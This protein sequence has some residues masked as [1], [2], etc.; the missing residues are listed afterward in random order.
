MSARRIGD[1]FVESLIIPHARILGKTRLG[2]SGS[3]WQ[4]GRL[5]VILLP[6]GTERFLSGEGIEIFGGNSKSEK[7]W[8]GSRLCWRLGFRSERERERE[9]GKK[10]PETFHGKR[11]LPTEHGF[12]QW[13]GSGT[14]K[15][16]L[17]PPV[18]TRAGPAGPQQ[19]PLV[20]TWGG[21]IEFRGSV[22][23]LPN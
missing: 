8:R 17:W 10:S 20:P 9:R 5:G 18:H 3:P 16:Q 2:G 1:G 11:A 22:S 19:M 13:S 6:A 15:N 23:L 7:L 4:R 12:S 14:S 21:N